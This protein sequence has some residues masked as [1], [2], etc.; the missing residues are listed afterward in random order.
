MSAATGPAIVDAGDPAS[1]DAVRRLFR[2]YAREVNECACFREF[3]RELAELPGPYAPPTGCLLLA[4]VDGQDAG[5]VALR[6]LADGSGEMKRLFVRPE[7]RAMRLGRRLAECVVQ[8]AVAAGFGALRLDT[9]PSMQTAIGM[10]RRMGFREVPAY[11][12]SP[13]PGV[14][15]MELNCAAG[16]AHDLAGRCG[17]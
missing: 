12:A 16:S 15:F 8:R 4:R 3:E 17:G 7:F 1:L 11:Y 6:G 5:C 2:E 13:L 10:Y 9:L 14:I